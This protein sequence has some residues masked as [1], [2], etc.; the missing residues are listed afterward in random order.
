MRLKMFV[1]KLIL[2]GLVLY[3][4]GEYEVTDIIQDTYKI[5]VPK[6]Q[7]GKFRYVLIKDDEGIL[8]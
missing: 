8:V 2:P 1:N 6:K 7:K 4:D 5:K 3:E